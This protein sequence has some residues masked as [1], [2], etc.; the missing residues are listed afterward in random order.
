MTCKECKKEIEGPFKYVAYLSMG[1]PVYWQKCE[2]CI[3]KSW[4]EFR[5]TLNYQELNK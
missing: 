1:K 3:R 4:L 2:S 5:K